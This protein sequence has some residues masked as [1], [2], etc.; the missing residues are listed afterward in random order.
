MHPSIHRAIGSCAGR[1]VLFEIQWNPLEPLDRNSLG[2]AD[3]SVYPPRILLCR[4]SLHVLVRQI[5][6]HSV[7]YRRNIRWSVLYRFY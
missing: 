1:S 4:R 3:L 7:R 6:L 5:N 2:D